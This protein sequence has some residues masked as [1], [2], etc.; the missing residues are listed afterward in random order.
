MDKMSKSIE[1]DQAQ[2]EK[3]IDRLN[4][5]DRRNSDQHSNFSTVLGRLLGGKQVD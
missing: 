5:S 4:E 2:H 1:Q 3:L